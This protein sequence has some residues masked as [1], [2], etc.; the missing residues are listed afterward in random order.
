[1][2]ITLYVKNQEHVKN[3]NINTKIQKYAVLSKILHN[4]LKWKA[5]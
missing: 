3:K 5:Q 4:F 1:M 2:F